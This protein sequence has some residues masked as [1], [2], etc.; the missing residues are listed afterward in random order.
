MGWASS[1]ASATRRPGPCWAGAP[2]LCF[3]DSAAVALLVWG[4]TYALPTWERERLARALQQAIGALRAY[5]AA[6]FTMPDDRAAMPRLARQRAYDAIRSLDE[7][8]S[9]SFAEPSG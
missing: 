3:D 6:V 8:R 1:S 7:V 5:S 9:R 4:A 2:R